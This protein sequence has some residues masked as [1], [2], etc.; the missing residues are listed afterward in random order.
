M[1]P[2]ESSSHGSSQHGSALGGRSRSNVGSNS[3]L[4]SLARTASDA[5]AASSIGDSHRPSTARASV[6]GLKGEDNARAEALKADG[7]RVRFSSAK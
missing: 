5:A 4:Y 7:V 3:N 1:R 2:S 6:G